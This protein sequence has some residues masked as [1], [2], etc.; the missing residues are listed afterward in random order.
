MTRRFLA[1]IPVRRAA[2]RSPAR[3]GSVPLAPG[4]ADRRPR[5]PAG[6]VPELLQAAVARE[7]RRLSPVPGGGPARPHL[8]RSDVGVRADGQAP[9]GGPGRA[10]RA[11]A[12][13]LPQGDRRVRD[14]LLRQ[15]REPQRDHGGEV[16]ARDLLRGLRQG[17]R[18]GA[19]A[20]ERSSAPRPS[21]RRRSSRSG[22]RSSIPNSS[23]SSPPR[24]RR[25]ARTSSPRRA[26]TTT[27]GS[28]PTTS[29]DSPR[30]IRSTRAWSRRTASWSRRSTGPAR[31]TARS[32]PGSTPRS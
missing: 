16:R 8:L 1:L 22:S 24:T 23:R 19:G 9:A 13:G 4:G 25:R 26:T 7:A 17:R 3:A 31:R 11:A 27:R 18:A 32:R 2:D 30:R 10:P 20:R 21:S 6:P 12:G 15:R 5:L 28:G 29:R 14:A